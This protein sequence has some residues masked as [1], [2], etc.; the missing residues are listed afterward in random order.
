M[1]HLAFKVDHYQYFVALLLLFRYLLIFLASLA[2]N[3]L[4]FSPDFQAKR[5][6]FTFHFRLPGAAL[7]ATKWFA[8]LPNFIT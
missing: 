8:H 2:A 5:S 4:S 3:P 1:S 7:L 6:I